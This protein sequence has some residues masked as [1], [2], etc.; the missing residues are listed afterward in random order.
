MLIWGRIDNIAIITFEI[1][2]TKV[3]GF[4][5]TLTIC[6]NLNE[7]KSIFVQEQTNICFT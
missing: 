2:E 6:L 4:I 3:N 7:L 1:L 5:E